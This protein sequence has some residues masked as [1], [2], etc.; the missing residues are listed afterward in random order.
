MLVLC[1]GKPTDNLEDFFHTM[2]EPATARVLPVP[3]PPDGERLAA[4]AERASIA[5]V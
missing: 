1:S 2:G 4:L 5:L 3:T